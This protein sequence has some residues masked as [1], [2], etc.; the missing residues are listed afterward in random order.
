MQAL[1]TAALL[2]PGILAPATHA[3]E[4]DAL[5]LQFSRYEEGGRDLLNV[6]SG[7]PPLRADSLHVSGGV[8][9]RDRIRVA[10]NLTQDTWSGA[11][12]VAV[13]PLA[14]NGNRPILRN[15]AQ[16]VVVSGA[17]PLVNGRV[18]LNAQHAV[19]GD[20][21]NVLIMSSA[22]PELRRQADISLD[23]PVPQLHGNA[24][25]VLGAGVSDEPDYRSHYGRIGGRVDLN[26]RLTTLKFGTSF[27]RS[28]TAAL[29]D[30]DL[31][32]YLT[33]RAYNTQLERSANSELLNGERR[34][35]N[36][37]IGLTQ[38]L[39]AV[40]VLDVGFALTR[41]S[42]FME[43]PYKAVTVVFTG[44]APGGTNGD[45]RAFLEQ[46]PDERRQLALHAHYARHFAELD[47]TLQL[48]Y[49]H[50]RDDWGIDTH[51]AE[52]GWA[53]AWRAWT[54]T[55]RLRYYTQTAADFHTAW[56][57]S[58]Q[59]YRTVTPGTGG[60]DPLITL[61]SPALLPTHFSS[62]H[63]LAAFG[64]LS[65]GLTVQRRFARG[66][67]LEAGLEYYT[68]A[69]NLGAS[70]DADSGYADFD[71]AMANVAFTVDLG[72][73]ERRLRREQ[74]AASAQHEHSQHTAHA[75]P[76][77]VQ[78]AH[79]ALARGTLMTG[80]R[81]NHMRQHGALL[82]G[83]GTA[84]DGAVVAAVCSINTRC[85]FAPADMSMTMHM[86]DLMYALDDTTT[87]MVM[88]QYMTMDMRLRELAG[89]P[90]PVPG[91]HE[92][93]HNEHVSGAIGD[94]LVAGIFN[95]HTAPMHSLHASVAVSV[96]TGKTDLQYRRQFQTDGGLMHYD[97]QT[98][99]GTWDLLPALT[100]TASG[101]QWHWGAQLSGTRRLES[102][103]DS[104]YRLGDEAQVSAWAT[105]ALS[106]RLSVSLRGV[107]LHRGDIDGAF[108]AYNAASGP[109]D[110]PHNHGGDFA[111]IG[112]G[113]N[114]DIAGSA[115][116]LEWLAP[117]H[118]DVN[119]FQLQR[120]GT[121]SASWHYN[122]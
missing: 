20:P 72:A 74:R 87:L 29:L 77:G 64:A 2:L 117:V 42:G 84:Q 107:W 120:Q 9:L 104:G 122:Y 85:K 15:G 97:M 12:P 4:P 82:H 58:E 52:L 38:V 18:Q 53:Q 80:Y 3:A 40:S 46:R 30:A 71:F 69:A 23:A 41:G 43:N 111:D 27:T 108:N 60:S 47:G 62:D 56:L 21:R 83:S 61:Y 66:L 49:N 57:V 32:P 68:R 8:T 81:A 45:V 50:S 67:T 106:Q 93:N 16:G 63:R 94:T 24:A 25:L 121:L 36:F 103:N 91:V 5:N 33:R 48:D 44:V 109:M 89:R 105:H 1:T 113:V 79:A 78:F 6:D 112:I 35:R 11:T 116:A 114:A 75:A 96:P 13:S 7:L 100:W 70:A 92:H 37:D 110:F 54:L 73:T 98:G 118:E 55:P 59:A 51:S 17:S 95:L 39:D 115:L 99:S 19:G 28:D 31:L 119:G 22:S 102:R 101:D 90:P 10:L 65:A 14:A 86:L 26:E 88:P 34:D 76:A